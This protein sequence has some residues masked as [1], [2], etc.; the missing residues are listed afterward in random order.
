MEGI[1]VNRA[2]VPGI[3]LSLDDL[4]GLLCPDVEIGRSG[5]VLDAAF[6]RA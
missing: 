3:R 6:T 1:A 2:P 5:L 4:L